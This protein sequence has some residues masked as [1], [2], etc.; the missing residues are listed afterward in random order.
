MRSKSRAKTDDPAYFHADRL[1]VPL[2]SWP[3]RRLC[4]EVHDVRR[5]GHGDDRNWASP[6]VMVSSARMANWLYALECVVVPCAIAV[7]M[8]ALFE[9]WDRWRRRT[10]GQHGL[11]PIDYHI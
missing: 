1:I 10:G 6:I 5:V 8:Y 7:V 2:S 3:P 4:A 9:T 11:P